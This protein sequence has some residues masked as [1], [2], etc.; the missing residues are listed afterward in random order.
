MFDKELFNKICDVSCEGDEL[1][2]FVTNIDKKEFDLNNAFNK[3]YK[4]ERIICAI[5]KYQAK[6]IDA[7]FLAYWSTAYGWII[8]GGFKI[9]NGDK[10]VSLK[11]FLIFEISDWLDSLSFFDGDDDFYHLK[12]YKTT[13]KVLDSVLQDVDDCEA[14]FAIDADEDDEDYDYYAHYVEVLIKNDNAKYFIKVYTD[15]IY[16]DDNVL[17]SQVKPEELENQATQLQKQGYRELKY[18][19]C[20]DEDD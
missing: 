11:D 14:V 13:V 7:K 8:M 1:K 19:A 15:C 6:K 10:S 4:V 18:G 5:E 2:K 3:Y 17:F 16:P 9:E 20:D 12:D